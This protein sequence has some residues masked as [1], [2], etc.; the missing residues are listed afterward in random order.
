MSATP[1]SPSLLQSGALPASPEAE[2]MLL[3]SI[4]L[5]ASHLAT[6]RA[7]LVPQAF[8]LNSHQ[9]IYRAFLTIADEKGEGFI[10]PVQVADYL[11]RTGEINQIGGPAYLASLY[12]GIPRFSNIDSYL[13]LVSEKYFLRRLLKLT[14]KTQD[15]I[16][17]NG[18]TASEVTENLLAWLQSSEI[19]TTPPADL[20]TEINLTLDSINKGEP[21]PIS[22]TGLSTGFLID[23]ITGGLKPG[24]IVL[25]ARPSVG[26]TSLALQMALNASMR[27]VNAGMTVTGSLPVCYFGSFEMSERQIIDRSICLLAGIDGEKYAKRQFSPD[28]LDCLE[29]ARQRI[30]QVVFK[31][32][33]R[34]RPSV[35]Y[36][37]DKCLQLRRKTGQLDLITLDYLQLMS[38]SSGSGGMNRH[39]EIAEITRGLKLLQREFSCP[40]VL[41]SQLSRES[42]KR[43]TR[44]PQL[45][46]L[47]DS[48]S[49]EADADAVLLIHNPFFGGA[50]DDGLLDDPA[51]NY[52]IA[53]AQ[54]NVE[55]IIAKNRLGATGSVKLGFDRTLGRFFN[56]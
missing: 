29:F 11:T 43:S 10:D 8:F 7:R 1:S 52:Q 24:L 22:G 3:G 4:L 56:L 55:I 21:G 12:D 2:K 48:G 37:R 27:Q 28:D 6:I 38:G 40:V 51:A 26:K 19:E 13:D 16:F 23:R 35:A 53:S 25:A 34:A 18:K 36:I 54:E 33:D 47:R 31:V 49:I 30:N 9:R 5:D 17:D 45:S 39:L 42:E 50:G 44:R 15:D 32:D 41:L 46:D 20:V 14:Q